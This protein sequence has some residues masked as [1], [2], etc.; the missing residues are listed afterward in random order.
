MPQGKTYVKV[1]SQTL[2]SNSASVTFSNLP[3]N[4]TDLVLVM[5]DKI[6]SGEESP[7]IQFNGDTGTNYSDTLLY[8]NG[9]SA[10][11]G[12]HTS[13][14]TPYFGNTNATDFN[15][16]IVNIMNYSNNT[17]YK[18]VLTRSSMPARLVAA[19]A[20]LWRSTAAITSIKIGVSGTANYVTG[21]TFTIYGI[22][23]AKAP[24]AVGGTITTDGSYWYHTFKSSGM[25]TAQDAIDSADLLVV[26]GGGG[27]SSLGGGGGAGGLLGFTSQALARN[28]AFTVTVGSGGAG[29]PNS[30]ADNRGTTG[31]DSQF[32]SLTLI[33]GGGGGG[34]SHAS[35]INGKDG[36]S[37]GGAGGYGTGSVGVNGSGGNATSGQGNN[38]G[39][40][41]GVAAG[42][43]YRG[44]GGGGA[45][46]VGATGTAS[47][48]GGAG[49]NSYSSWATATNTG[50]SGYYAGGGGGG[51]DYRVNTTYGAGANGGG[52]GGNGSTAPTAGTA[53]SG[54]GGGSGGYRDSYG[55][56]AGA[57]GGSGIV[58]VRYPV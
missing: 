31:N 53:N 18:T 30:G 52:D 32:G 24:K 35:Y 1:A 28:T 9:T 4:F 41:Y 3:Q 12:K 7:W 51:A 39:A 20:V 42:N 37:G 15:N 2:G 40:G 45:G 23:A 25:F 26:A 11:S 8:G 29:G 55:Q 33:K 21:T 13:L 54:G 57:Q 14:A 43:L 46:A 6:S 44:G 17:T 16:Q 56:N 47:G 27:G 34:D 22:E 36:G 48:N 19:T 38:G 10:L 58:I 50:V 5:N 49:S